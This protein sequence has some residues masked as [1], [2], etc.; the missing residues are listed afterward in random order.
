[1]D[2]ILLEPFYL[3]LTLSVL[4]SHHVLLFSFLK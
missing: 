4:L 3:L 1:M 2:A